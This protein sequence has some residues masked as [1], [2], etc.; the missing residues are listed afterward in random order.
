MASTATTLE[1]RR[2]RHGRVP[3]AVRERQVLE[4]AEQLF[5][6]EGYGAASMD[7]L[8]RRVGVSKPVVYALFGS[9]EALWR[10]CVED[11]AA[12]LEAAI[13]RAAAAEPDPA[14]Q[15]ER[16][17]LAFFEFVATHRRL[18]EALAWDRGPFA[19]DAAA[20]RRH[21]D[22]LVTRLFT[23]A[24]GRRGAVVEEAKVA[25][26]AQTVNGA[27]E[28]LARWWGEHTD[29]PPAQLTRWALELLLPGLLA[30]LDG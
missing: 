20:I 22:V 23:A 2:Y 21:Q 1:L 12:G 30:Q 27:L 11:L 15:M 18:W 9:K 28:A 4:A 8:S 24:A 3:R 6:E 25:A 17:T 29:V 10:R 26:L 5:A 14:R 7:E 13:V 16:C 19:E